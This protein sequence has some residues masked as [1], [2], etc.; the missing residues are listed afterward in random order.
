MTIEKQNQ[1]NLNAQQRRLLR[2]AVLRDWALISLRRQR[3]ERQQQHL[4]RCYEASEDLR[5]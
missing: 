5:P 4:E 2:R 3:V 1:I